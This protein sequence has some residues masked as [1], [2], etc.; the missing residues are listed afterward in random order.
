MPRRYGKILICLLAFVLAGTFYCLKSDKEQ[1]FTWSSETGQSIQQPEADRTDMQKLQLESQQTSR[2]EQQEQGT[3]KRIY[4]HIC[5]EVRQPGVYE[6][7][8]GCRLYELLELA[9]GATEQ[10][11]PD[12]MNLAKVLSDGERIV[13]PSQEEASVPVRQETEQE[14][15][16]VNLN[17]ATLEQL[18][19]LPGVGKAKASDII[20]Y[21]ETN[22]SFREITDIMK[23]SG[24]KDALFQKIKSLITV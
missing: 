5:G 24:I 14:D 4:V 15:G 12:A 19:T 3:V 8:E 21:R 17:T 20:E 11:L 18:M 2:A 9:G 22:G 13:I 16:L 6:V 23:I 1:A 7:Q 10:G